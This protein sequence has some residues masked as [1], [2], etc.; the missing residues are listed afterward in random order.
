[1]Q[2]QAS[3]PQYYNRAGYAARYNN[4][5]KQ[6]NVNF[7]FNPIT[8]AVKTGKK[9][10]GFVTDGLA[11]MFGWLG[12]T[13]PVQNLVDFLKETNYQKHIAAF[14]GVVLSSFYMVDT[15]KSKK[16]EKDQKM[17]LIINQG[18]VCALS[19]A[20]AYTI[21]NW[22]DKKFA[23]FV[24]TIG[25]ANIQDE[26]VRNAMVKLHAN[27]DSYEVLE[28]TTKILKTPEQ[29][30]NKQILEAFD[31][32]QKL[33]EVKTKLKGNKYA[34]K[35]FAQLETHK[36]PKKLLQENYD[37]TEEFTKALTQ[38]FQL[39]KDKIKS[40]EELVQKGEA[41]DAV[42]RVLANIKTIA[43]EEKDKAGKAAEFCLQEMKYSPVLKKLFLKDGFK[44]SMEI[45]SEGDSILS[46]RIKGFKFAK[47]IMVFAMIYR[48]IAPV[49]ATP[50]ANSISDKLDARKKA[51]KAQ[52]PA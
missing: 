37:K 26:T 43:K 23:N 33:E 21:D 44:N 27:K 30:M 1:M 5:K 10:G 22:L 47:S 3:T 45:I 46:K 2:I 15:A 11:Y 12:G 20:G 28:E 4:R 49:I 52:A 50:I 32:P 25:V 40:L 51:A 36:E 38:R 41:D 19:T 24:D 39:K 29:V 31:D 17:P 7:G 9:G 42:K 35:L 16:I 48:F 13:K 18:A 14:V 34:D 6:N 8:S